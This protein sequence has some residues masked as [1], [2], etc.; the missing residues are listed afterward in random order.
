MRGPEHR[1]TPGVAPTHRR[2][3]PAARPAPSSTSPSGLLLQLQVAAG[4]RAVASMLAGPV[5]V[6]QRDEAGWRAGGTTKAGD[7]NY[8]TRDVG[9]I[10]RIPIEG[11]TLGNQRDFAGNERQKTDESAAGRAIVLVPSAL[12]A[13]QTVDVMLYFHGFTGRAA[14]YA[15]SFRQHSQAGTVRDVD[16]DRIEAQIEAAGTKQLI[17]V[18]PI[19]V[20][21]SDFGKIP[22]DAY[23]NEVLG[24][25]LAVGELKDRAGK[26]V[27]KVPARGR[28]VLSGHSG[29]GAKVVNSLNDTTGTKP[30]EIALFEGF[31]WGGAIKVRNWMRD[32]LDG[33]RKLPEAD[34]AAAIAKIPIFRAYFTT[35]GGYAAG[36]GWLRTWLATWFED[37]GKE[38]G[39]D[40]PAL[41]ARFKVEELTG[42][43]HETVVRGIGDAAKEGPLADALG[44]LDD[45]TRASELEH[46]GSVTWHQP[47]KKKAQAGKGRKKGGKAKAGSKAASTSGS[48]PTSG[49]TPAIPTPTSTP[50]AGQT[51]GSTPTTSGSTTASSGRRVSGP[52]PS[53][54]TGPLGPAGPGP[55]GRGRAGRVGPGP[56]G[57]TGPTG[58]VAGP[59]GRAGAGGRR[60]QV[61]G[62]A[63]QDPTL[64]ADPGAQTDPNQGLRTMT[65]EKRDK[66][67]EDTQTQQTTTGTEEDRAALAAVLEG[68]D[69]PQTVETWFA[70]MVPNAT[71]LGKT[72]RATSAGGVPG[73]HKELHDKLKEAERRL[74]AKYPGKTAA[75][76]GTDLDLRDIG[77]LRKPKKATGKQTPSYHVFGL[78]VDI[79]PGTN[80]FVGNAKVKKKKG[81]TKEKKAELTANRSPRII[82]RAMLLLHGETFDVEAKLATTK[83][84][85]ATIKALE[86]YDIH[87]RASDAL[88][89]YLKLADDLEGP[90]L[91]GLVE[92]RLAAGDTNDL[93]WW[94]TRIRTDRDQIGN[95]DFGNAPHP[96][97]TGYLDISRDIV[98]ALVTSGLTWGGT[99]NKDK[100]IMHF[101]WRSG[102]IQQ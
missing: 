94:K 82:E 48:A 89:S 14:D 87:R 52:P 51:V 2:A 33:V 6:A 41:E 91:R 22:F 9:A 97:D 72:I 100:D 53:G 49:T 95:W 12:D 18:L 79:D 27:T 23:I 74:M 86:S 101:D 60:R 93:A 46:K 4:N 25:V 75:Q 16:Q 44:L 69:P 59:A 64:A 30:A 55:A 83:G 84:V 10:R 76:I 92:A 21:T 28:L 1:L 31:L 42:A 47:R 35:G 50:G 26:P 70:S 102:T 20:G 40:R 65:D 71:F 32:K 63:T 85:S 36:H 77:G 43:G 58:P 34:R 96:E 13:T 39:A 38:L 73:V 81:M 8:A 19:G 11:L 5:P 29:G 15:A 24:R 78:A 37:H 62:R 98:E 54:Q 68:L 45:P 57:P 3:E 66:L 56:T 80:P 67:I 7:W 61:T 99:Y 17:A 90:T 88:S